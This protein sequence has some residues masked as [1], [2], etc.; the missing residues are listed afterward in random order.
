MDDVSGDAEDA[1]SYGGGGPFGPPGVIPQLP[2]VTVQKDAAGFRLSPPIDLLPQI[3]NVSLCAA[4]LLQP[5]LMDDLVAHCALRFRQLVPKRSPTG[6]A[7]PVALNL[8]LAVPC[9][10]TDSHA[11]TVRLVPATTASGGSSTRSPFASSPGVSAITPV[12]VVL[13]R[14]PTLTAGFSGVDFGGLT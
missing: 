12:T 11:Q 14:F 9:A 5:L 10:G 13:G 1:S 6:T 2:P 8:W 3:L 7:E 4:K